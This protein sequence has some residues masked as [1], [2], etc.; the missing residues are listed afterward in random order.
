[1]PHLQSKD[2]AYCGANEPASHESCSG[3][4]ENDIVWNL[5]IH[6]CHHGILSLDSMSQFKLLHVFDGLF[7]GDTV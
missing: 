5:K 4:Q 6:C 1:M 7:P 2:I 3:F